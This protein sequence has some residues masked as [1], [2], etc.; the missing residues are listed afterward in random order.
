MIRR[1]LITRRSF[2]KLS[3]TALGALL[4]G[5][6]LDGCTTL[7]PA[8]T[9][10]PA[11]SSTPQPPFNPN[12]FIRIDQDGTVNLII[13][14]S[15]MGQGVR[16]ALAMIL[17]E[18]LEAD[19][20]S[21]HV[22]QADAVDTLNQVTSG[23]GSVSINYGP[24]REAGA[25]ARD[26]LISAAAKTWGVSTAE[27]K[28]EQGAVIQIAT[29]R[30]L[31][32]GELVLAAKGTNAVSPTGLKDE[33]DFK[34]IGTSLL[35][36]D[37]PEIITGKAIYG[38][39]VRIPGLSFASVAR[40]PVL[41]GTVKSYDD[42]AAKAVPGVKTIVQ[43]KNGVAVVAE[44]TWA[45]IQG[46]A[47]LKITWDEGSLTALSSDS[48]RQRLVDAVNKASSDNSAGALTSLEAVYETPYLA[49]A[50]MEPVNCVADVRSDRCEVWAP[51][52]NPMDVR[53]FVRN[54]VNVPTTVHVTLLGGGFGR[55]LE[56]DFAVEA[57]LISKAVSGPVQVVWTREDDIQHDFYRQ[58]T[59]HLL[60]TGWDQDGKLGFLHHYMAGQGI[61]GLAYH[62]GKEVLDEGLPVSYNIAERLPLSVLVNTPV[63]TGPWRAVMS[64]PNAFANECFL[65]E[66]AVALKKDPYQ[67][68]MDLLNDDDPLKPV[69]QLAAS[70][71]NWGSSLPGGHG[72]GIACHNTY[73]LTQVAMVA[74]VS[75]K[76]GVVH[77][78]K[79][80]CA[81]NCGRVIN[82][83]MV[84]HQMEGGIVFG[85]TSLL[86]GEITIE[87]G[88]VMQSNFSD[89]PLLQL[90]EMPEVEVHILPDSRAPQGVGEMGVPPLVPAVVNALF[91][92]TGKRI[93]HTPIKAEDLH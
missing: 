6:Y 63:P 84:V 26:I 92:A 53:D 73:G 5:T 45:A 2:L 10:T 54:N 76:A 16:T 30:K 42:T 15:E 3:F 70:K 69:L 82:P 22:E 83:D 57:A 41:G 17:A 88:R 47:A 91:A 29:G 28:A 62:V 93:R 36:V 89:Y 33:K 7:E 11:A 61:N 80:V 81:I 1:N 51:T 46:R 85:L 72:R 21:V 34:L 38:L 43:I 79:V 9:A 20:K 12:L 67:F 18:E 23:S 90:H 71:A 50:P 74:E 58:A 75:V 31:S 13:H 64:G 37:E 55:K 25:A 86:K 35:R 87:Q 8:A 32:Y 77:V 48:I 78:H 59:Y 68:R 66:V 49:H 39:D 44:N 19:W 60:R 52:Q 40:S 4:V 24:L 56:V 65:D 14:R 27:C